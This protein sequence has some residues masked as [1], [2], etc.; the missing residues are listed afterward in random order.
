MPTNSL[1]KR[2][3]PQGK[4]ELAHRHPHPGGLEAQRNE[5]VVLEVLANLGQVD[6][7]GHADRLDLLLRPDAR[8]QEDLRGTDRAGAQHDLFG[9]EDTDPFPARRLIFDAPGDDVTRFSLQDD[10]G[11]LNLRDHGEVR[12]LLHRTFQERVVRARSLA[13]TGGGLSERHH[14]RR[15]ASVPAVVITDGD[16]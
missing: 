10:P 12:S 9:S 16:S 4:P 8:Q 11:D 1:S 14:T 7:A 13:I 15:P 3:G 6:P 5:E 2:V